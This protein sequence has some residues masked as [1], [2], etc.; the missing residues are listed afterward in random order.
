MVTLPGWAQVVEWEHGF[1][2]KNVIATR[3][4]SPMI[5]YNIGFRF[6][7]DTHNSDR[8]EIASF[9]AANGG[10][11][12]QMGGYPGAEVIVVFI[13]VTNKELANKMLPSFLPKLDE[14]IQSI[15]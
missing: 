13:G 10:A 15:R 2:T 6:P 7:N 3:Y 1:K 4:K 12:Y 9:I 5:G 11:I 8:E 14:H